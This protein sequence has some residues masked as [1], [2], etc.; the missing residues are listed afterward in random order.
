MSIAS[1]MMR[2]A[3]VAAS[4]F[5]SGGGGGATTVSYPSFPTKPVGS[6]D[7]LITAGAGAA[8]VSANTLV[9][10][11]SA[12][13]TAG[14]NSAVVLPDVMAS[15]LFSVT[16]TVGGLGSAS[17][18]RAVGPGAF[19]ADG[20]VGVYAR[21]AA[22]SSTATI[23]SWVGGVETPRASVSSQ[24]A[25]TGDTL[26]LTPTVT[27]GVVKWT[28]TKN[29]APIGAG[30]FWEDTAHAVDLPGAHP[31]VAFRH[32]YSA[33]QLGSRGVSALSAAT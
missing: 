32:Q 10:G 13:S 1:R 29:G 26:T 12:T 24:L 9:E 7:V 17:N 30:L 4:R 14:Y 21:L 5:I 33:G 19:S 15:S 31:G 11:N 22:Q 28:V 23:N 27:A 2:R 18:N 16:V 25:N 3:A 6:V 20:S 8:V